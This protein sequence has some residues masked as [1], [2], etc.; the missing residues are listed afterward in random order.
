MFV[1][2]NLRDQWQLLRTECAEEQITSVEHICIVY[3]SYS[4]SFK[5]TMQGSMYIYTS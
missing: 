3:C 4:T 5:Q 2:F 1:V